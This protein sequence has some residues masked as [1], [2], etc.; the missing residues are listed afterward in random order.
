MTRVENNTI[1][2]FSMSSAYYEES[3]RSG[4][5]Y[6]FLH[7]LNQ[8][9]DLRSSIISSRIGRK[10]GGTDRLYLSD[11]RQAMKEFDYAIVK[12]LIERNFL[13]IAQK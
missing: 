13:E 4:N 5:P 9:K 10:M 8:Q 1:S 12:A 7:P 2:I 3:Q 6:L 11:W